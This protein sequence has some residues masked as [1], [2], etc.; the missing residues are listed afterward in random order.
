MQSSGQASTLSVIHVMR[1]VF[2]FAIHCHTCL[3]YNACQTM[4]YMSGVYSLLQYIAGQQMT[5][6]PYYIS[7]IPD[8]RAPTAVDDTVEASL[9]WCDLTESSCQSS[10]AHPQQFMPCHHRLE[11]YSCA[12]QTVPGGCRLWP[13]HG[14]MAEDGTERQ[15]LSQPALRGHEQPA[16]H[17]QC[18]G[19][20]K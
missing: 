6:L 8:T 14:Y 13:M 20:C 10:R 12:C 3:S 4:S 19:A 17:K 16:A 11:S 2:P 9:S 7:A 1:R 18:S 5:N 15:S